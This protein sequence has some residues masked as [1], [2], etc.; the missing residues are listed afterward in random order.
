MSASWAKDTVSEAPKII[1]TP[2]NGSNPGLTRIVYDPNADSSKR[3]VAEFS[4]LTE[5]S[6]TTSQLDAAFGL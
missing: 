2:I 1:Y 5:V 4:Y 3:L 6:E